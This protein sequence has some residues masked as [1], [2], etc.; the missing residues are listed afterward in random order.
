MDL[1][2]MGRLNLVLREGWLWIEV[3]KVRK[4]VADRGMRRRSVDGSAEINSL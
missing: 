1:T 3:V 2:V 4:V